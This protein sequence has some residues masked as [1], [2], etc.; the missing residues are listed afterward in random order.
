[1]VPAFKGA[2]GMGD[3]FVQLVDYLQRMHEVLDGLGQSKS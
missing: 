1:L 2:A 3:G